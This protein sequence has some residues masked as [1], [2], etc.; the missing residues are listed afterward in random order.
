MP[1]LLLFISYLTE[2]VF[3]LT[4]LVDNMVGECRWQKEGKVNNIII[5]FV[6]NIII[7]RIIIVID[8]SRS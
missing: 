7:I 6:N 8:K 5:I 2:L 4:C 1:L 3:R